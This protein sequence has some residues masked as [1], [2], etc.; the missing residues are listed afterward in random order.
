M[1]STTNDAQVCDIYL[2]YDTE[3]KTFY[4]VHAPINTEDYEPT[5]IRLTNENGET[6]IVPFN[7]I[8]LD[9]LIRELI[10]YE[11]ADLV[12]MV[13]ELFTKPFTGSTEKYLAYLFILKQYQYDIVDNVGT[14]ANWRNLLTKHNISYDMSVFDGIMDALYGHYTNPDYVISYMEEL[15]EHP[16]FLRKTAESGKNTFDALCATKS[17]KIAFENIVLYDIECLCNL[18]CDCINDKTIVDESLLQQ[19]CQVPFII[20]HYIDVNGGVLGSDDNRIR[21][22]LTYLSKLTRQ[23]L[24]TDNA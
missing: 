2:R 8:H 11:S 10:K 1:N 7:N 13:C 6:D 17:N 21:E 14:P 9:A 18:V 16:L 3:T 24:S 23:A 5:Y 20:E 12:D 4:V 22:I 19:L 15:F